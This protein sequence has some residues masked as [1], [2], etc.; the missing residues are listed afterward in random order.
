MTLRGLVFLML[1]GVA[2]SIVSGLVVERFTAPGLERTLWF[3]VPV[4]VVLWLGGLYGE[5]RGWIRGSAQLG[6]RG[7]K[8]TGDSK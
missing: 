7:H 4:A 8:S 6:R 1:I 5:R 3:A 2:A